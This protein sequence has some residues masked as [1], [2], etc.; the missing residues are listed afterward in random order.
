MSIVTCELCTTVYDYIAL[1]VPLALAGLS[2]L[3]I[4]LVFA[5]KPASSSRKTSSTRRVSGMFPGSDAYVDLEDEMFSIDAHLSR[6]DKLVSHGMDMTP[7]GKEASRNREVLGRES[8]RFANFDPFALGTGTYVPV[9]S[10]QHKRETSDASGRS[11]LVMTA[12]DK[13]G[14]VELNMR[15]VVDEGGDPF[16]NDEYYVS[17]GKKHPTSSEPMTKATRTGDPFF[18]DLFDNDELEF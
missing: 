11:Q 4:A 1:I 12:D 18:D 6:F 9:F 15:D 13:K 8:S 14:E 10:P 3:V 7:T 17:S 5:C 2:V 16:V